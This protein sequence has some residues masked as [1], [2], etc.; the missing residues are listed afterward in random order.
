[1][2]AE[3]EA[4]AAWEEELFLDELDVDGVL[5]V[6]DERLGS[7]VLS[8]EAEISA[9][10]GLGGEEDLMAEQ[11]SVHDREEC[12]DCRMD[13]VLAGVGSCSTAYLAEAPAGGES[14][15]GAGD[16]MGDWYVDELFEAGAGIWSE[17]RTGCSVDGC[18]WDW[19]ICTEQYFCSLWE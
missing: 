8:L 9:A 17:G 4:E 12:E 1:M 13:D 7:V 5:L 3:A 10:A 16:D 2:E 15:C 11:C 19:G 18:Q 14:P 6:D